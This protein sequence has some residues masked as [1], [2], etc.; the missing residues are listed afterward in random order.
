MFFGALAFWLYLCSVQ[1]NIYTMVLKIYDDIGEWSGV[2]FA[3]TIAQIDKIPAE[4]N[5]IKLL[6][7]SHG[8]ECAEAFKIY[9]ALRETGK[10]IHAHVV[11]ECS[12]AA[13]LLLLAASKGN[14]TANPNAKILIHNPYCMLVGDANELQKTAEEL[15]EITDKFISVYVERTGT[16]AETLAAIMNE[17]KPISAERAQSL[18]FIDTIKTPLSNFNNMN[19]TIKSAFV[20]LGNA[21]GFDTPAPIL[22]LLVETADGQTLEFERDDGAPEI[23]DKVNAPDGSYLMPSGET[24]V[25]SE[26]VLVEI[27]PAEEPEPEP[28]PENINAVRIAE[29]ERENAELRA[30]IEELNA[31]AMSENDREILA[32]VNVAGGRE[33]LAK[34]TSGAANFTPDTT[35]E[36]KNKPE[37]Y[38]AYRARKHTK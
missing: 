23:G 27:I 6:I 36:D 17:N 9:D 7:N 5:E 10:T 16:P 12:S 30:Q 29:L 15:Q 38:R 20:A 31:H 32:A 33:W 34:I 24:F 14:R 26:G 13:T 25:I 1:H 22:A 11:G 18:G 19:K 3:D 8:G 28:E 21:L 37:S 2:N 35:H 4:D